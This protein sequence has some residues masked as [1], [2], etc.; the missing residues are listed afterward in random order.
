MLIIKKLAL[1]IRDFDHEFA[2]YLNNLAIKIYKNEKI[3]LEEKEC[4]KEEAINIYINMNLDN[5]YLKSFVSIDE[6]I[7]KLNKIK[8]EKNEDFIDKLASRLY[9]WFIN[10]SKGG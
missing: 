7:E 9:K 1:E 2:T 10:I 5:P 4:K 6:A 3:D 8:E